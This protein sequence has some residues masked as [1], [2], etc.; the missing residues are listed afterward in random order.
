THVG[1]T[2]PDDQFPL[3]LPSPQGEGESSTA[4]RQIATS[5]TPQ[6]LTLRIIGDGPMRKPLEGLATSLGLAERVTFE[7]AVPQSKVLDFYERAHIL[8]LASQTE[9]WPKVIAEGMAFGLVCIGSNRG[10]VPQML[11]AG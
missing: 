4:S 5:N 11:E 10:L 8:V 2:K 7:G 3:T 6:S 9:G 1:Y